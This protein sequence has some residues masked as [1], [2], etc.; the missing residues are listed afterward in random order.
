MNIHRKEAQ[1]LNPEQSNE[2]SLGKLGEVSQ[3]DWEVVS[4]L[5]EKPRAYPE[6]CISSWR[7][8]D[9]LSLMLPTEQVIW[10]N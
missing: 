2:L 10:K 3:R 7:G 6:S 5:E 4:E 9:P 1:R 8:S